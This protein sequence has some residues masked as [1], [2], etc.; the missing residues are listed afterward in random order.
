MRL[1]LRIPIGAKNQIL[2]LKF[3]EKKLTDFLGRSP[4]DEELANSM[5]IRP[6]R[7][8]LLRPYLRTSR[9]SAETFEKGGRNDEKSF[10]HFSNPIKMFEKDELEILLKE[11]TPREK[12]VLSL[13]F[14]LGS[15]SKPLSIKEAAAEMG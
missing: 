12:K 8:A 15:K 4:T 3:K 14:G 13:K 11:L 7:V 10:E 2:H 9:D 5:G 6:K 1:G